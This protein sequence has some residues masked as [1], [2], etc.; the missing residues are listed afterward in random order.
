MERRKNEDSSSYRGYKLF[1]SEDWFE[2]VRINYSIASIPLFRVDV[3]LSSESIWFGA[4]TTRTES[5]DKIEL[6]EVL[7]LSHLS[8]GQYFGSRKVLKVFIIYNNVNG[9]DQTL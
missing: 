4:K 8:S 9:I 2:V 6:R 7:R 5:D 3:L 1:L